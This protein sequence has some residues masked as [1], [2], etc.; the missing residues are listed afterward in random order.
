MLMEKQKHLII[1]VIIFLLGVT[2]GV[3]QYIG[4][5]NTFFA[6]ATA[7]NPGHSWEE[8]ECTTELCVGTSVGIG[9][10]TPTANLDVNGNIR[11]RGQ[12]Y[13]VNN[14]SGS[15]GQVLTRESAGLAWGDAQGGVDTSGIVGSMPYLGEDGLTWNPHTPLTWE[16]STHSVYDCDL[17]GGTFYQTGATGSICQL[18]G[19]DVS[20]PEG[21]QQ[22]DNWQRYSIASWG[23]DYCGR[24]LSTGPTTWSNQVSYYKTPGTLYG[25]HNG[26]TGRCYLSAYWYEATGKRVLNVVTTNNYSLNRIEVG[27]Y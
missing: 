13:D 19:T 1:I 25:Y 4:T 27:V 15:V 9:T 6:E 10:E 5:W 21:W 2:F 7:P 17:I 20:V 3:G 23:G 16:G 22:A 8:M 24:H 14:S 11:I 12:F 18:T 26:T